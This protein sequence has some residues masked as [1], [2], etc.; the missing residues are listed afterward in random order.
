MTGW[1]MGR[2]DDRAG[3]VTTEAAT[4]SINT[5]GIFDALSMP[6]YGRAVLSPLC[7]SIPFYCY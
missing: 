3:Y 6:W 4:P 7:P 5:V 1:E 2:C